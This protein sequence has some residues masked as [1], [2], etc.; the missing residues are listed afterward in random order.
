MQKIR[1]RAIRYGCDFRRNEWTLYQDFRA[2]KARYPGELKPG[3]AFLFVSCTQDQL[4]WFLHADELE[5]DGKTPLRFIDSR[6]WRLQ[7]T[8]WN[9]ALLGNYAQ[10]VGIELKGIRLF[11][12]AF[13]EDRRRRERL[14]QAAA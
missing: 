7:G 3:E 13:N 2:D 1:L 4:I 8:T 10:A 9:P 14:G 6:R 12:D 11:Q 5:R